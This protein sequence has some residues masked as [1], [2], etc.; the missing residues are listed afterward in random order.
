MRDIDAL[1]CANGRS[2]ADFNCLPIRDPENLIETVNHLIIQEL[3]YDRASLEVDAGLLVKALNDDKKKLL[4]VSWKRLTVREEVFFVYGYGD[5]GKTFLWNA[6]ASTIRAKGDIV[7]TIASSGIAATLL[8]GG[9][10][11]HSRFTIPLQVN[12]LCV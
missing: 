12:E 5:T 10:T 3:S 9:R 11:A 7:L 1:L 6:L 2:L 4:H 8:P